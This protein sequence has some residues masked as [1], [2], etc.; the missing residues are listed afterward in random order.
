MANGPNSSDQSALGNSTSAL[1]ALATARSE[2]TFSDYKPAYTASQAVAEANRCFYC[3]DAPCMHACPTKI[4]IPQ[5]IRKIATGNDRGSA[6]TILDANILG[7]S[8]ARVCPVEVLCVGSCVYNAL[9]HP[10]IQ[11][12]RLQRHSTDRAL[13]ENWQF[14][15]AGAD[16]GKRV[17][18]IG[19]GP[20]SLAC[21]HDLR[22]LGHACTIFEKRDVV[23]GLNTTGVAPY[24]MK[25]DAALAEVDWLL[26]IGGIEIRTGVEIGRHVTLQQLEA[27]YDAVFFGAGLGEDTSL[28]ATG[29]DLDGIHGAVAYIE[30]IKLGF[31][32]LTNIKSVLVVG[33]GN[34]AMDCMREMLGLN[35][36]NVTLVYR[37]TAAGMSGYAHEWKAAQVL[38]AKAHW[39]AV[40]VAFS[41]QGTGQGTGQGKVQRAELAVLDANKQPTGTTLEVAADLVLMAI[42]QSK[43]GAMLANLSGIS[44]AKGVVQADES[45]FTGRPKWYVGG[46]AR[47]GGKEVVDAAADGKRAAAA[48]GIALA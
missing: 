12:G 8:C 20:A 36:P 37:G 32:D 16:T 14:Y 7:M 30:R 41:G 31:E 44:I 5:F 33:G 35:I 28:R 2:T 10:P 3:S 29:E 38:G 27:D 4:D 46:D 22:R 45:G 11:I 1:L 13:N 42:G 40:P 18:L 9:G 25:A 6:K 48:I 43:L 19:A 24:K 15:T 17:A 26:A 21:A 34:T 47:N 39:Q 23:G